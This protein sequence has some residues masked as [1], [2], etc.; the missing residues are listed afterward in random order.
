MGM[1]V[2]TTE[3]K[4]SPSTMRMKAGTHTITVQNK[5]ELRHTFSFNGLGEEVTVTPG[6]T[7]T[8]TI[9]VEPGRYSYVCRVLDHEGLG[10]HGEL[11]VVKA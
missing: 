6:Q 4:F 9:T 1:T 3:M 8:L 7:K 5:G 10:M 2:A 11:Q